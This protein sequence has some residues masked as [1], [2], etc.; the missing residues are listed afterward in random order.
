MQIFLHVLT[1]EVKNVTGTLKVCLKK[2]I[3]LKN[4]WVTPTFYVIKWK[5]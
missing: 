4:A 5:Q 1:G 3:A 2:S